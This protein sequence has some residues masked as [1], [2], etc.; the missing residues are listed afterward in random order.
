M[1]ELLQFDWKTDIPRFKRIWAAAECHALLVG[2]TY[3]RIER[4]EQESL[5]K[6]D[7]D[8]AGAEL[9]KL[10]P[11]VWVRNESMHPI[12]ETSP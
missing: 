6:I 7:V 5:F 10:L 1:Q 2:A 9:A 11:P 8:Y 4:G 12:E 3:L